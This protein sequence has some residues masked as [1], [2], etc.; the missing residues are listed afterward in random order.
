MSTVNP[1][2]QRFED[3]AAD[4]VALQV[5]PGELRAAE[6]VDSALS[7]FRFGVEP[8][9]LRDAWGDEAAD[10]AALAV[11]L[12]GNTG[13][14]A[15]TPNPA[16]VRG[17]EQR[18]A[19]AFDA[20][21]ARVRRS[22]FGSIFGGRTELALVGG[23]AL[24]LAIAAF[25]LNP[26]TGI[27]PYSTPTAIAGTESAT[28]TA[29]LAT[30]E[31]RIT[32]SPDGS[33]G[34]VAGG[35]MR[36]AVDRWSQNPAE[37][38]SV[39]V[40]AAERA[41]VPIERAT[42]VPAGELRTQA[43]GKRFTDPSST[44]HAPISGSGDTQAMNT[45]TPTFSVLTVTTLPVADDLI[46]RA[47]IEAPA[48]AYATAAW[49]MRLPRPI[50]MAVADLPAPLPSAATI[51]AGKHRLMALADRLRVERRGGWNGAAA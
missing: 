49:S 10:F 20:R 11:R 5:T 21:P 36:R 47:R 14:T 7:A 23:A 45:H 44:P 1:E 43:L 35:R 22:W 17:L 32:S 13:H 27:A 26:G 30:P 18:M 2:T 33:L 38:R 46:P 19:V 48:W 25:L 42:Q 40:P 37:M 29:T 31:V 4:T 39:A 6:A 15:P 51:E 16:F 34:S 9:A 12:A 24:A 28:Q 50:A 8:P 3:R 41:P